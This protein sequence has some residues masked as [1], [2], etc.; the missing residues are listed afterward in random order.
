[1]PIKYTLLH[2]DSDKEGESLNKCNFQHDDGVDPHFAFQDQTCI[3]NLY[4][5]EADGH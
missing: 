3:A 5:P 2:I 4:S 1:M